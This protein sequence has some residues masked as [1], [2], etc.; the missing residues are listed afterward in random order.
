MKPS[1]KSHGMEVFG[2]V[3][4]ALTMDWALSHF[5]QVF[6][7]NSPMEL[8]RREA[9]AVKGVCTRCT[10]NKQHRQT[11]VAKGHVLKSYSIKSS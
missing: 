8:V 11:V 6:R 4:G 3:H 7:H 10:A 5:S 2:A 9:E 1:L